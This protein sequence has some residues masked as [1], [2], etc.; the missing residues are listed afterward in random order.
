[1][2]EPAAR[3]IEASGSLER[4][5]AH[6]LNNL[7]TGIGGCARAALAKLDDG[8]PAHPFV[9]EINATAQRLS[10]QARLAGVLARTAGLRADPTELDAALR[11]QEP[12]FAEL[13]RDT[14]P[15]ELRL[16]GRGACVVLGRGELEAL[17]SIL[18]LHLHETTRA[19]H[20]LMIATSSAGARHVVLLLFEDGEGDGGL[21]FE[22]V[23][24]GDF[25]GLGMSVAEA[26]LRRA[27]ARVEREPVT[28]PRRAIRLTLPCIPAPAQ[29]T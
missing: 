13:V 20:P 7:L 10:V 5:L 1:M 28:A 15:V 6:E 23:G 27:G 29:G 11:D 8:H 14:R 17:V 4:A 21:T 19:D 22:D 9:A 12:R 3:R 25:S 26:V 18:V 2:E 24:V 16:G